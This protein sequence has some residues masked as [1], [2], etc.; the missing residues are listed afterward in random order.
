MSRLPIQRFT[1]LGDDLVPDFSLSIEGFD[2]GKGKAL[3]DAV[4]PLIE[5]VSIEYD[6]EETTIFELT[7]INQPEEAVSNTGGFG[8]PVNWSAVLDS[9]AFQEGN[10]IDLF[11][12]YAGQRLFMGRTEIVKWAPEFGPNGP[13]S[14]VIKGFDG[15]HRMTE[16]NQFKVGAKIGTGTTTARKR[17]RKRKTS[18][19]ESDDLIVKRIAEKYGFG[20]DTD[21][22]DKRPKGARV[23]D[24]STTDWQFLLKLAQIN[25]FD[26]S[27]D[28]DDTKK[29]YVVRFKRRS[30]IGSGIYKFTYNGQDGSLISASPEFQVKDQ[31]TDVEVLVYDKKRKK[32]ERTIVSDPVPAEDV[33]LKQVG[34]GDFT[35]KKEITVGARVRFSAFGQA[36]D[37]ISGKPFKSKK[38]AER[39]AQNWLKENERELMILQ[40]VVIGIEDLRPLQVHQ[41]AGLSTRI[42]GLYKFTNVKHDMTVGRPYRCEFTAHRVLSSDVSRRKV[43]TTTQQSQ[44]GTQAGG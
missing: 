4:R 2:A 25:R 11:M 38:E 21:A 34:V 14:F 17:K 5:S 13:T 35:A 37:A 6:E 18:Y 26:L 19:K 22:V 31:K 36:F 32:I 3:F 9:K 30:D 33:K 23:Q 41:I 29:K 40:G 43:T 16:G 8:S 10:A 1:A 24:S 15:R 44:V 28:Y 27:V 42:D 20:S 39:F 12:G 7:I